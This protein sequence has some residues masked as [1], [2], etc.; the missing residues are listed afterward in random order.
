MQILIYCRFSF[1]QSEDELSIRSDDKSLNE[2]KS[3]E[4]SLVKKQ[5]ELDK[6]Y[7]RNDDSLLKSPPKSFLSDLPP[8]GAPNPTAN[9]G[10]KGLA[11]LK[12]APSP[13]EKVKNEPKEGNRKSTQNS[14]K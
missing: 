4:I 3:P 5:S 10:K 1:K 6:T 11:P 13:A 9:A 7:T 12:K 8:L 14:I 2:L